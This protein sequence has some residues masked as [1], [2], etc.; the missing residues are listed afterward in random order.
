MMYPNAMTQTNALSWTPAQPSSRSLISHRG[1]RYS[2]L[3]AIAAASGRACP[4]V[5]GCLSLLQEQHAARTRQKWSRDTAPRDDPQQK[6]VKILLKNEE[7]NKTKSGLFSLFLSH[8]HNFGSVFFDSPSGEEGPRGL[9]RYLGS[10]IV[11]RTGWQVFD[12]PTGE[13]E[14]EKK[15]ER[16]REITK[17]REERGELMLFGTA[18]GLLPPG[19]KAYS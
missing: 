15:R 2:F 19:W 6:R 14:R 8:L 11:A 4:G 5:V 9:R 18:P 7:A 3:F 17:P 13:K 1:P 10:G 12:T 16:E